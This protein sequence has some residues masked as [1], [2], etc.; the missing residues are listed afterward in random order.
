MAYVSKEM[1]A[2]IAVVIKQLCKQYKVKATL[3]VSHHSTLM[4][5]VKQGSID[6]VGN[7]LDV[8]GKRAEYN[9]DAYMR[10][11]TTLTP[12]PYHYQNHFDGIT[13]EFLSKAFDAL[14]GADYYDRSDIS[15]DYFDCSHYVRINVGKWDKPYLLVE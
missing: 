13:K 3:S 8:S 7:Y 4:L 12:N 1:K 11:L 14:K 15:S 10:A 5:N 9:N 6:F 2:K